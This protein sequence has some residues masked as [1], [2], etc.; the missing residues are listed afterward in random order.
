MA[1]PDPWVSWWLG[2]VPAALRY[3]RRHRPDAI[4]STYPIATAHLIG[5]TLQALTRV[6]WVADFRD[7]MTEDEYPRDPMVRRAYQWIERRTISRASRVVFTAP[8]TLH[9]YRSRYPS[10]AAAR[11]AVILNGYDE[12]DFRH[13]PVS[14]ASP[15][16]AT[17][18]LRLVHSGLIYPE[19]RDP[20][21][22]FRAL[23]RLRTDG[24]VSERTLRI[25][26]RA[27]GLDSRY[28]AMLTQLR[29]AEVVRILPSLPFR[30]ALQ[31][32]VES[33]ALVLLQGKSCNHQIPAKAYE[34]LRA[35]KPILALTDPRGDTAALLREMGGATI[36]DLANEAEL[37]AAIPQFLHH[38]RAGTH[39]LPAA[40]KIRLYSRERQARQ[41]AM[42]LQEII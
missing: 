5:L 40:E 23:S 16:P 27:A 18:A 3:I 38:V 19:E 32:C 11:C 7:S 20:V 25:D 42:C 1:L 36:A 39:T 22:F 29:I 30:Q 28:V 35:R 26:L 31:E 33:D 21:P 9:M 10:L 12:A 4:W 6:P 15:S 34:Y 24:L 8:S 41:L 13:L 14:A 2:A 37:Y 17:A